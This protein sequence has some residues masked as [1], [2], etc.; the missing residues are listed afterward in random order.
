MTVGVRQLVMKW[1]EHDGYDQYM[2]HDGYEQCVGKRWRDT[3]GR[4]D[5]IP[6]HRSLESP[7]SP[8]FSLVLPDDL[9]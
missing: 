4:E 9:L 3:A 2:E 1:L 5:F 7:C 8:H 6:Q